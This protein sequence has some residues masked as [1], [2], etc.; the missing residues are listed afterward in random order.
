MT[1]D[2]SKLLKDVRPTKSIDLDGNPV[3]GAKPK[4]DQKAIAWLYQVT[5]PGQEPPKPA[6]RSAAWDAIVADI[7]RTVEIRGLLSPVRLLAV[8]ICIVMLGGILLFRPHASRNDRSVPVVRPLPAVAQAKKPAKVAVY[9]VGGVRRPG[10]YFLMSHPRVVDALLAAGGPTRDANLLTVNLAETLEDSER[11]NIPTFNPPADDQDDTSDDSLLNASR[12][13]TLATD[14]NPSSDNR[15]AIYVAGA[16]CRPGVYYFDAGVRNCI[17]L[18]AAGG[19]TPE[20]NTAAINLAA[21]IEDGTQ[22]YVPTRKEAPN[23]RANKIDGPID[24]GADVAASPSHAAPKISVQAVK[25]SGRID[26]VVVDVAGAVRKPGVYRLR[27]G[28]RYEDALKA[29]HG[30]TLDANTDAINLAAPA[31]DSTQL[32]VP[33]CRE[34]PGG[35]PIFDDALASSKTSSTP[36]DGTKLVVH[37]AGAVRH[38]G[39]YRLEPGVRDIDALKAAGGSTLGANLRLV[40]LSQYVEDGMQLYIPRKQHAARYEQEAS[41]R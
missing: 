26:G 22:L 25:W 3:A 8:A 7:A 13:P 38:P 30:P 40:N 31:Q 9:I 29:A 1:A 24:S 39:V 37:V 6:A 5:Q 17:A 27:P 21:H 19:P 34:N 28:A 12:Q 14:T 36:A 20:A 10:V 18:S 16:V 15:V 32:Y 23:A 41:A 2:I 35:A 4:T 11:I 33:T